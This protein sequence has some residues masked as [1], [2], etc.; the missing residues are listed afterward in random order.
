MHISFKIITY[1]KN[2]YFKDNLSY[3]LCCSEVKQ[4]ITQEKQKQVFS[5]KKILGGF[6]MVKEK[7]ILKNLGTTKK[8]LEKIY[9][10]LVTETKEFY[11]EYS[12]ED[13]NGRGLPALY[14]CIFVDEE[15]E[16]IEW[17]CGW[18]YNNSFF[19]SCSH[20]FDILLN[21]VHATDAF[22]FLKDYNS[23]ALEGEKATEI[24][25]EMCAAIAEMWPLEFKD[26]ETVFSEIIEYYSYLAD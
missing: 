13:D 1:I 17:E 3:C 18:F 6:I 19:D 15:R 25:V 11:A 22:D 12:I 14:S 24:T 21:I 23:E 10:T 20:D 4:K 8:K 2:T 7:K 26:F 5:F 16:E 9:N